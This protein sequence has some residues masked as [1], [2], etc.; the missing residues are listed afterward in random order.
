MA[1]PKS[2]SSLVQHGDYSEDDAAED[3]EESKRAQGG[4]IIKIPQGKTTVRAIPPKPGG[5]WKRKSFMHYVEVPGAG[6]VAINCARLLAKKP[7]LICKTEQKMVASGN[8][9][10]FQKASRIKA[11]ARWYCNVVE[12]GAEENGPRILAFG[13]MIND[14]LIEIRQDA[15]DGGDFVHPTK[16]FDLRIVR[17]GDGPNNTKY[18]VTAAKQRPTPLAADTKTMNELIENQHSLDRWLEAPDLDEQKAKLSGED[19]DE[20]DKPRKPSRASR[21]IEDETDDDEEVDTEID[22][23]DKSGEEDDDEE[24]VVN[25]E[26]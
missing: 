23:E 15:D 10:D 17:K 16:G 11:K 18:L 7:C 5:K 4:V 2:G 21:S 3:A 26:D 24:I 22:D 25:I 6:S 13:P 14:Q 12:R 1:K 20:D 8:K 19:D 9:R